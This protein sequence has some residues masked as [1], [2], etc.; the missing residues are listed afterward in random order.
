MSEVLTCLPRCLLPP[1]HQFHFALPACR[2]RYCGI[3][4]RG[5]SV[6]RWGGSESD[7][8]GQNNVLLPLGGIVDV[9]RCTPSQSVPTPC[10]IYTGSIVDVL[11]RPST[12]PSGL[13]QLPKM[14][15]GEWWTWWELRLLILARVSYIF[16]ARSNSHRPWVGVA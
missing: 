11:L 3:P 12:R 9:G 13:N 4:H 5:T 16:Q 8:W 15:F 14:R 2:G 10:S 6:V 7:F 1:H